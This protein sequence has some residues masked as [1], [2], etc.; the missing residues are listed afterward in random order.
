MAATY[1]PNHRHPKIHI[2]KLEDDYAEF[3]LSDTDASLA[4]ALRRIMIAEV[5]TIAIDLVD[6]ENNTSVLNDEFV[7]HRLGLIP[8]VSDYAK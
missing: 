8:L 5:P 1:I 2:R 4:N 3:I 6:F 7:A